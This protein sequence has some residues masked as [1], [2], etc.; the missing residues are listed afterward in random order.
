MYVDNSLYSNDIN[1]IMEYNI[2]Q[3]VKD[4]RVCLDENDVQ[5]IL[6]ASEANTLQLDDII[7]S[8]IG[9]AID[10][11]LTSAPLELLGIGVEA[12]GDGI[13]VEWEDGNIAD[14]GELR[15]CSIARPE[16]YLRLVGA[17]MPDWDYVVVEP[18]SMYSDE[19]KMQ[20]SR[21][22]GI[23]GNPQRPIVAEVVRGSGCYIELYTSRSREIEFVRYIPRTSV[24]E[25][26]VSVD[27]PHASLY[28][29]IV[30]QIAGLVC[31]TL[32]EAEHAQTLFGI[33]EGLLASGEAKQ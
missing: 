17:K 31:V 18:I 20:K 16:D 12:T 4:V 30:Y 3:L 29:V 25:S 15:M 14:D 9:E 26:S 21:Y 28:R 27:I 8:K 2:S 33:A 7:K 19:Y 22:S 24:Q 32:H 6:L 5:N 10:G 13:A 23:K 11:V 1:T